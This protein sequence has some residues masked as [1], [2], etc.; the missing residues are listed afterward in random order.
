MSMSAQRARQSGQRREED[1]PADAPDQTQKSKPDERAS[2]ITDDVLVDIDR[3]L[4][5]Q[6]FGEDEKVTP[7]EFEKRAKKRMDDYQQKGGQ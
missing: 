6:L 7:E 2:A 5:A 1:E 4:E 3:A